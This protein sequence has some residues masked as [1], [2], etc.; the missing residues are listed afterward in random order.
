LFN[1][2]NESKMKKSIY[3]LILIFI[4]NCSGFAQYWQQGVNYKIDCSLDTKQHIITG[5]E[6]LVYTNNSSETLNELL[7][8]LYQNSYTPGSYSRQ[9]YNIKTD[10]KE[11]PESDWG[12]TKLSE[13]KNESGETLQFNIDNTIASIKLSKP[14]LPGVKYTLKIKFSTKFSSNQ[15]RMNYKT[16]DW[17]N[18]QYSVAQWYPKVCVFDKFGWHDDQDFGHEFYGDFGTFDVNISLPAHFILDATGVLQNKDE[19]LPDDLLKKIDIKNFKDKPY[20]EKPSVIIPET[21]ALK[22]WK[23]HA[24]NVH[25]FAW[26]ADPTFRRGFS[27]WNGIQVIAY[28]REYKA[29][30]W[31]DAADFTAKVIEIYSKD[32]GKYVYPKMIVSDVDNGMEYPMLT[33]DGGESP[34]Y[35]GLLAHEVGHNWFYGIIGNNETEEAFLDE[36]FTQFIESWSMERLTNKDGT[37]RDVGEY[38]PGSPPF[39]TDY[40]ERSCYQ[41]YF[42]LAMA[43][44]ENK[45]TTHSDWM[46]DNFAYGTTVYHKPATMLYNLQYVLGNEVFLKAMRDYFKEWSLKH[47]YHQ[48]F[49]EAVRKS[50]RRDL[51]W[52]FEQWLNTTKKCDYRIL[53]VKTDDN[54]GD[55]ENPFTAKIKLERVGDMMMPVDL[56]VTLDNDKTIDYN[57]PVD[58][59]PKDEK[60][61]IALPKWTGWND[62]NRFYTAKINIPAEVSK[63][64]IDPSR[65]LAD[66]NRLDNK[67]P[68][69]DFEFK[70]GHPLNPPQSSFYVAQMLWHP[71]L[72]FN[73]IS[74]I[75]LGL[76]FSFEYPRNFRMSLVKS[77]LNIW[78]GVRDQKPNIEFDV[79][80]PNKLLGNLA[81]SETYLNIMEGRAVGFISFNKRFTEKLYSDDYTTLDVTLKHFQLYDTKYILD[82]F[83]WNK[84]KVNSL[85]I[86]VT[87]SDN[88]GNHT[89]RN[90]LNFMTTVMGTYYDF[91]KLTYI[92]VSNTDFANLNIK[93]RIFAGYTRGEVPAQEQFYLGGASPID[94]YTTG[95]PGAYFRSRGLIPNQM[96]RDGHVY[97][98]GGTNVRGYQE[99]NISGTRAFSASVVISGE[100]LRNIAGLITPYLFYDIGNVD[101]EI[102]KGFIMNFFTPFKHD[103]G[104]GLNINFP[105][106]FSLIGLRSISVDF[107]IWL[108]HP[109][110]ILSHKDNFDF[111]WLIGFNRDI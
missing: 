73:D 20:G 58:R 87:R 105:R 66:M 82:D 3:L 36:G 52:F 35:Y 71:D 19:A 15:H 89:A 98:E 77:Y 59:Y 49:I 74:G 62:W 64:E 57:I 90:T 21:S 40:R 101:S 110:F 33:M 81:V 69:P 29:A 42:N 14:L 18:L 37:M 68:F 47:P 72:W 104:L 9:K 85:N 56:R 23:F 70:L 13:V 102:R 44:Y 27:E 55:K 79:R 34:S 48:D 80:T 11:Y 100:K 43:G 97:L 63:V 12:W 83:R 75:K 99:Q 92:G 84:G 39:R 78:Y 31:Q 17:G 106:P 5:D 38:V 111:R 88:Y 91:S 32:F 95:Y 10:L 108:S 30:R 109:D 6:T 65:R 103:A 67:W 7:F 93:T 53:S 94:E 96:M 51:Y 4:I 2:L 107:P 41:N 61:F 22:T 86:S 76:N 54:P 16:D 24:E 8:H 50:S 60:G 46:T 1:Y 28:A 25:D 45:I 26:I